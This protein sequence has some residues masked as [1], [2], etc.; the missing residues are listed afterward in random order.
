MAF[1]SPCMA[2][3][4]SIC[5]TIKLTPSL[6]SGGDAK[7]LTVFSAND[8]SMIAVMLL[9]LAAGIMQLLVALLYF[10]DVRNDAEQCG[11]LYRVHNEGYIIR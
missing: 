1:G 2:D 11:Y 4:S 3:Q 6:L 9:D 8:S 7:T 10:R 5:C